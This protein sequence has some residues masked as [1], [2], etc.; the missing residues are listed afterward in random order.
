MVALQRLICG[1]NLLVESGDALRFEVETPQGL[2]SAF[3]FRW[4][5]AVHAY[6]NSCRH[7]PV[8]L[9]WNPGKFLDESGLYLIC[10]THGARYAPDTGRCVDGPCRGQGLQRVEVGESD[11]NVYLITNS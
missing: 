5:G 7:V 3:V 11:G 8:E 1:S 4:R 6:L 2:R 9:D 10:A